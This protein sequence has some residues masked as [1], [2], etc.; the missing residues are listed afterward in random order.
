VAQRDVSNIPNFLAPPELEA[1]ARRVAAEHGCKILGIL[2]VPGLPV[3]IGRIDH[4]SEWTE[5]QFDAFRAALVKAVE[6]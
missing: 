1:R 5:A 3:A 6:V 2:P 4:P